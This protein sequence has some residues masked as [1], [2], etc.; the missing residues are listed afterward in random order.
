MPKFIFFTT[1]DNQ[2]IRKLQTENFLKFVEPVQEKKK[3]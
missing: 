2:E 1:M 3:G